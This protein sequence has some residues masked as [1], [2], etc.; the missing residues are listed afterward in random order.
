[1]SPLEWPQ[2]RAR[3]EVLL[4][5]QFR[6]GITQQAIAKKS[7]LPGQ[8]AIS[9]LLRQSGRRGPALMRVLKLLHGLDVRPSTFFR[10]LEE[11][12]A[13]EAPP[14]PLE[15][16]L[17][18]DAITPRERAIARHAVQLVELVVGKEPGVIDRRRRGARPPRVRR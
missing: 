1:M 8:P 18:I 3:L 14:V 2:I 4:E 5:A 7:D 9:Q 15:Q 16:P 13:A 12:S 6:Q 17:A 10:A 11:P